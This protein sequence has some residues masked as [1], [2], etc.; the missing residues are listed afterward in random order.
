MTF[1]NTG[2]IDRLMSS[3][4]SIVV[5]F[6][7]TFNWEWAPSVSLHT[8]IRPGEKYVFAQV[9]RPLRDKTFDR[10]MLGSARAVCPRHLFCATCCVCAA[11]ISCQSPDS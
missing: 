10:L 9:Y 6:A 11:T 3:G 1:D 4:R 8:D 7:H 2:V 5:Y